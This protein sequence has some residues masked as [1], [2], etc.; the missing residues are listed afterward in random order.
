MLSRPFLLSTSGLGNIRN[1]R[2]DGCRLRRTQRVDRRRAGK[3]NAV[4]AESLRNSVSNFR[5]GESPI[6]E[7][8]L[9]GAEF[10]PGILA[11]RPKTC[12]GRSGSFDNWKREGFVRGSRGFRNQLLRQIFGVALFERPECAVCDQRQPLIIL[13]E[14]VE[15][16][17]AGLL[18][19]LQCYKWHSNWAPLEKRPRR[20]QPPALA[21]RLLPIGKSLTRTTL[22]R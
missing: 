15:L 13:G 18:E 20:A 17:S 12:R 22:T 5:C 3:I 16:R 11:Q 8:R 9:R 21:R 4:V 7:T 14:I 2:A 1:L 10:W 6:G 19:P